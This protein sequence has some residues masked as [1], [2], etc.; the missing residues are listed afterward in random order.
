MKIFTESQLNA[1]SEKASALV[2]LEKYVKEGTVVKDVD[3]IDLLE[4]AVGNL[5]D[6][7]D[8]NRTLGVLRVR[9]VKAVPKDR[10]SGIRCLES[11]L[12][13]WDLVSAQQVGAHLA[14]PCHWPC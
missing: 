3:G 1:P 10:N 9:F 2:T 12:L 7:R 13:H 14:P 4:W 6:E 11:C 8:F 5:Q